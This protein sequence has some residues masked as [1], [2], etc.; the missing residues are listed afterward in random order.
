M[1]SNLSKSGGFRD[2]DR[3]FRHGTVPPGDRALLEGFLDGSDG[4]AF[5]ALVDRHGPMVMGVCR[6]L[7]ASPHDADDAFQATFLI[8]VRKAGHLRDADRLGPW[9]YG[10]ATRVAAKARARAARS[11]GR[12]EGFV[13]DLPGAEDRSS[14]WL[15]VRP[16]LDAELGRIP[17]KMRDVLVL[18]LLEG[19]TAEEAARRLACPL[20]TVKSRLARGRDALRVRLTGRGVAPAVAVAA[21]SHV[22]SSHASAALLRTTLGLVAASP[23]TI[24][25]GVISLTRGVAPAML[26][27]TTLAAS[28]IL[29]GLVATGLGTTWWKGAAMAQAP[30][31]ERP[32]GVEEKKTI[33]NLKS[34]L[35][36]LHNY[37]TSYDHFPPAATYGPDGQPGLS[38]R[39]ALLPYLGEAALY[40]SFKRDEPWD[41]PTNKALLARMPAVFETPNAPT[42][43]GE[44]RI[45]GFAGKGAFFEGSQGT[46]ISEM[47]DGTSN[48]LAIALASEAVPWTKPGELVAAEGQPFPPLDSSNPKGY[49]IGLVDGSVQLV[50]KGDDAFLRALITRNGG[51]VIVMHSDTPITKQ[52]PQIVMVPVIEQA[53]AEE[54]GENPDR[55]DPTEARLRA[56]EEKLDLILKRLDAISTAT[57]AKP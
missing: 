22:F 50:R 35:L 4:S 51:E 11:K 54:Q 31:R 7:L 33:A 12:H 55:I 46:R 16:I 21:T 34:V 39:V 40:E 1:R 2:L 53:P 8:F 47:I 14:D 24:A 28:L 13:E 37:Y 48:T 43:R 36:A 9:L 6:R 15:D 19:A 41:S 3:L 27:K 45:R 17:A 49:R 56:V 10:V 30:G 32:A 26:T 29:G 25:P 52:R 18:C 57:P 5:E 42:K 38:W 23:A 20:G 44:T